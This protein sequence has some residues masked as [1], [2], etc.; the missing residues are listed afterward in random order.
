MLI[1]GIVCIVIAIVLVFQV[2]SN[3]KKLD[4]I[5]S[6]EPHTVEFLESLRT[7]MAEGVGQGSLSYLTEVKG[8]IE[9]EETLVSELANVG[10]VY[11]SMTIERRYEETYYETDDKGNRHRR[12]RSGSETM[13]HNERHVPF[14][15]RDSTGKILIKAGGAE[16]IAEKVLSKFEPASIASG[17]RISFGG[18]SMEV[19]SMGMIG[20]RKTTGYSFEEY[21]ISVGRDIYVNGQATDRDGELCI[22]SPGKD[23]K[24]I[25]SVKSEEEL[26]QDVGSAILWMKIGAAAAAVGGVVMTL[27]GIM[28][29]K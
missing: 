25:V 17:G 9:C 28:H 14:Y 27:M 29:H 3:K 1:A 13:A 18:F 21:A 19:P 23:S 22:A 26:I 2:S 16:F 12:T 7:S 4:A 24:F 8:K 10:C 20:D 11:Y 6:V 15:V 5:Q